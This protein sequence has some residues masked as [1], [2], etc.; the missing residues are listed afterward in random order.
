MCSDKPMGPSCMVAR[1]MR[2]DGRLRRRLAGLGVGI[3][4]PFF[5][6]AWILFSWT[7]VGVLGRHRERASTLALL[8]LMIV[9]L[10]LSTIVVFL[11]DRSHRREVR[12]RE[13]AR[14]RQFAQMHKFRIMTEQARELSALYK[15]DGRFVY[16]SPSY[17]SV[18]GHDPEDLLHKRQE[19]LVHPEDLQ[20][21]GTWRPG[22]LGHFRLRDVEGRWRWVEG[23]FYGVEW[24]GRP[25]VVGVARDVTELRRAQRAA[26][27]YAERTRALSRRLLAVQEEQRRHL[28][29]ELHDEVGQTL[30]AMK[31]TLKRLPAPTTPTEQASWHD[32]E[33]GLDHV[34][35]I[36][37]TLSRE[38]HPTLL[39]DFGLAPALARL[40]ARAD[41]DGRL[42]VTLRFDPDP[43]PR[44]TNEIETVVYRVVQEAFTN[45]LRHAGASR[46]L[47]DLRAQAEQVD[48]HLEDDGR[49]FDVER[50]RRRALEGGSF[51]LLGMEE[52]VRLAGGRLTLTSRS[53]HGVV[54]DVRL[55]RQPGGWA[56]WVR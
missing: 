11:L 51:G 41:A 4:Y 25:H 29:R 12:T 20:R 16:A 53:G 55:P 8:A 26:I 56:R 54:I 43:F 18:L 27:E 6:V 33:L 42:R 2:R 28:A 31:L 21:L 46:F 15:P 22:R 49:G 47:V 14:A 44:L 36:V 45:A 19:D 7:V 40:T 24:E 9:F 1:L 32:V 5:G 38:L 13:E 23:Y 34:L 48:L 35:A 50:E 17:R 39:N 3:V 10:G 52:R 30:T 37:R